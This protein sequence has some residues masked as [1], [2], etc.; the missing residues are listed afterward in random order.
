[1][2]PAGVDV[3]TASINNGVLITAGNGQEMVIKGLDE[4]TFVASDPFA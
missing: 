4:Q 3:S 2:I 1:M